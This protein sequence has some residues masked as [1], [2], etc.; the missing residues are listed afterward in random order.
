M[1]SSKN[2]HQKSLNLSVLPTLLTMKKTT[3]YVLA[4][5]LVTGLTSYVLV[6][7]SENANPLKNILD[8]AKE[9]K[10]PMFVILYNMNVEGWS[11]A[12]PNGA[13]FRHQYKVITNADNPRKMKIRVTKPL[14]VS[15]D[16]FFEHYH[17]LDMQ[18]ASKVASDQGNQV[19]LIASPPGYAHYIGNKKMG[20][21]VKRDEK[22]VWKF[23]RRYRNLARVCNANNFAVSK[24]RF[25][26][27]FHNY[28]ERQG[29][30][31]KSDEKAFYG[32]GSTFSRQS[33]RT[34]PFYDDERENNVRAFYKYQSR[35]G[36]NGQNIRSRSGNAGK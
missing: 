30:Y 3:L 36:R 8:E 4:A 7:T 5:I 25:M 22:I 33:R 18:I 28:R 20:R 13:R 23:R 12:N 11:E 19:S 17:N 26:H 6:N 32:T 14:P 10:L 15:K 24:T 27:Y 34:S 35:V 21:W 2:L 29:Y 1:P 9:D 31:G 16:M